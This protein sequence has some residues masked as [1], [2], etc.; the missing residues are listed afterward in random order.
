MKEKLEKIGQKSLFVITKSKNE[1]DEIWEAAIEI[2]ELAHEVYNLLL[3]KEQNRD[4]S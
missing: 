3:A 2:N 4:N 1:D